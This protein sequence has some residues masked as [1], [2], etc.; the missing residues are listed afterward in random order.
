M[1]THK[2][3]I[4]QYRKAKRVAGDAIVLIQVGDFYET[5]DE[6][7]TK[8]SKLLGLALTVYH[9]GGVGDVTMVGFP[10]HAS[11]T[12]LDKLTKCGCAVSIVK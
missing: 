8:V 2:S 11:N 1:E 6:D 3:P 9:F 5:F 4:E 10:G 7:A 12:Y